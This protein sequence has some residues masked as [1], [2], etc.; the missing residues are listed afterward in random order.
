MGRSNMFANIENT[1]QFASKEEIIDIALTSVAEL[2]EGCEEVGFGE[3]T[4]RNLLLLGV[5]MGVAREGNLNDDEKDIIDGVFGK[6]INGGLDVIYGIANEKSS[7]ND[8]VLL[9]QIVQVGNVV[10]MPL[11]YY[12]LALAYVDGTIE[13]DFAERL[14]S[15]YGT[16]L[17]IEF[18]NSG[19]EEVPTPKIPLTE[20]ETNIVKWFEV[21]DTLHTL[22]D[23]QAQFVGIEASELQNALD[24]LVDKGVLYS[25]ETIM[26]NTYGLA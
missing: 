13:E 22:S 4:F 24:S 23:V 17:L 19:L 7:E 15:I 12:I 11:L 5:K 6:L 14:D 25:C 8:Y 20:L 9:E 21:D 18:M 26:G 16:N 10:A 2:S 1:F 3:N